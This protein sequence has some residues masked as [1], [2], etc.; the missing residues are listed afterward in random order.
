[1]K[2]KAIQKGYYNLK[3]RNPGDEFHIMDKKD[4]SKNWMFAVD[5]KEM[6]DENVSDPGLDQKV[7]KNMTVEQLQ[8]YCKENGLSGY[9]S[10]KKKDLVHA[11]NND[12][13]NVVD[14]SNVI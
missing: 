8:D 9:E 3:R 10:L 5:Q 1:M 4:F 14:E 12:K 13:L 2:V 11:I 7:D 6:N